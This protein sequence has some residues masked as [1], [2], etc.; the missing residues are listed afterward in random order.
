MEDKKEEFT[1]VKN[2][3][4]KLDLKQ[5]IEMNKIIIDTIKYELLGRKII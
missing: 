5:L 3:I 2:E 1:K 4:L